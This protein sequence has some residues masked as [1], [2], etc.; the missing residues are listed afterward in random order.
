[1][2]IWDHEIFNLNNLKEEGIELFTKRQNLRLVQI[3]S[4]CWGKINVKFKFGLG[5]IENIVGEGQN[6]D[7]QHFLLFSQ[8][9]QK[10]SVSGLLKVGI[11]W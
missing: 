10:P 2:Y 5:R 9:F 3:E 8:C 7:Y 11:V 1:M 4:I 6:A